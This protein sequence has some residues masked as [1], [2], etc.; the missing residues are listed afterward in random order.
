MEDAWRTCRPLEAGHGQE[1][2]NS[3]S[4]GGER[5]ELDRTATASSTCAGAT[6]GRV[7]AWHRQVQADA[8]A[9]PRRTRRLVQRQSASPNGFD[10]DGHSSYHRA[11]DIRMR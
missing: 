5:S 11:N 10:L 2:S 1:D 3:P 4:G 8:L 6:P 7:L 9:A